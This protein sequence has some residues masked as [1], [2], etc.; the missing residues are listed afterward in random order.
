MQKAFYS[1][2]HERRIGEY[3]LPVGSVVIGAGNRTQDAAIVRPMSSALI[4][5]MVH[6]HLRASYADWEEWAW[7]AGLHAL[8]L[9]Y[10]KAR[11]DHLWSQPPKHEEP[12]STPRAWHML[13]DALN[14]LGERIE[15][16]MLET[17]AYGSLT[18]AH[19][20][21]LKSWFKQRNSRYT[22]DA[23]LEGS[24][25]WP[26]APEDRDLLY[27]L[28]QS[29][30]GR[31]LLDLPEQREAIGGNARDLAHQAK[32]RLKTLSEISLEMAQVVVARD[33]GQSLPD[34]FIVEVARDLPRLI[35]RRA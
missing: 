32:A 11:P 4:N 15:P 26:H 6:V 29:L 25:Q 14:A 35:E 23:I 10:L 27:F 13:S 2:I 20:Q 8:V 17:L 21:S 16:A 5:R 1:L 28:A 12:F 19:A 34:W 33:E 22:L 24:V 9:D 3:A 18:P 7:G 31:L 30:R